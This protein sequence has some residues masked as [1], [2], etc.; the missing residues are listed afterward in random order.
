MSEPIPDEPLDED[1]LDEAAED[2]EAG[3]LGH[4]DQLP[5]PGPGEDDEDGTAEETGALVDEDEDPGVPLPD[6]PHN[7]A[8]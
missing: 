4:P 2:D 7:P 1:D 5:T 8:E 6:D 3:E